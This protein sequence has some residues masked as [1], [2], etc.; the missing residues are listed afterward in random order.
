MREHKAYLIFDRVRPGMRMTASVLLVAVGFL[1]QLL[2]RNI[3]AGLPFIAA[4]AVLNMLR[5]ISI[6]KIAPKRLTWQ[7]VTPAKIDDVVDQCD[8]VKDFRS[9]NTGCIV[10]VVLLVFGFAFG[11]PLIISLLPSVPFALTAT[12]VNALILFTVLGLSGRRS[13]WMPPALDLKARIVQRMLTAPAVASDPGIF[14]VPYIEVGEGT[15]GAFPHDV[16]FLVKFR[17]APDDLIGL[18]GQISVNTV[19]GRSYP[20]FYMVI[21]AKPAF[22]LLKRCENLKPDRLVIEHKRTGEVDVVVIRQRT[23]KTS[24]YHTDD[25]VQ[26]AILCQGISLT[27]KVM[28]VT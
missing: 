19:K 22:G 21:I 28:T 24:G 16:R 6:R 4:C 18:Q 17:D 8:R 9:S 20:Y 7:E 27:K 11:A 26:D 13:A 14:A 2:A 10:I 15:D 5:N 23:T 1:V 12:I 25:D 3:L